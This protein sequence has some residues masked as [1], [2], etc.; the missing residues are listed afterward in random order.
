MPCCVSGPKSVSLR[1]NCYRFIRCFLFCLNPETAHCFTLNLLK[2]F[3]N[4]GLLKLFVKSVR[5]PV[6]VMGLDFDNPVGLAAGFDKNA[7]YV[8]VLFALGF[9]F[10]EVGTVTP[11]PQ[12]GKP[13][14]R[15][16]RLVKARALINRM[17][18]N[19][20][21]VDHLVA[22]LRRR[23]SRGVVGVN[24]GKNK[25]TPMEKA[26]DDY[27]YCLERVYQVADY[28]VVNISTPNTENLRQLQHHDYLDEFLEKVNRR[29]NELAAQFAVRKPLLVKLSP[30]V[31]EYS[32]AET[33]AVIE[34][35]QM[36]GVIA[37]NTSLNREG[38]EGLPNA[39]EQGGLSGAPIGVRSD[40]VVREIVALRKAA[41]PIIGVGGIEDA[42]TAERK[43]AAGADLLQVYTGF[44]YQGVKVI[45]AVIP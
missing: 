31:A 24:I 36:D 9:G 39:Q 33:V 38:V 44:V 7:D 2:I 40:A 30:D 6:T 5:K 17:G 4:I 11:R 3:N 14:P 13:R 18:F 45:G 43:L 34:R 25:D 20:K 12:P 42:V 26:V 27:L 29:R 23:K 10:V 35:H 41:L 32:L 37:T 22:N 21:G 1:V 15:L 8:D 16:F 28:I 19:N